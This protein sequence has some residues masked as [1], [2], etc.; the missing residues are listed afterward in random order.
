[1]LAQYTLLPPRNPAIAE[2]LE[3]TINAISQQREKSDA[4]SQP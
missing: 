1:V 2:E 3:I 4:V